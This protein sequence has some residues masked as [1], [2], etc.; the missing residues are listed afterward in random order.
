MMALMIIPVLNIEK[1]SIAC[2]VIVLME[3]VSIVFYV[4]CLQTILL[5]F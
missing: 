5:I 2:R 3:Q 4:E 1:H